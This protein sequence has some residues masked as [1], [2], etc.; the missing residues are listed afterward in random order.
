MLSPCQG[1]SFSLKMHVTDFWNSLAFLLVLYFPWEIL[2]NWFLV[3][4]G[5]EHRCWAVPV[6]FGDA[7]LK[8]GVTNRNVFFRDHR[9][10]VAGLAFFG[11]R[12]LLFLLVPGR[13]ELLLKYGKPCRE[14]QLKMFSN[15]THTRDLFGK[16]SFAPHPAGGDVRDMNRRC[17]CWLWD[18]DHLEESRED[19][20]C[21]WTME[22]L[23]Q[24][25]VWRS[26][27]GK[28]LSPVIV[29]S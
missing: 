14:E 25:C 3:H 22:L 18:A 19:A 1:S 21:Q 20:W 12:L 27:N 23:P 2:L 26:P 28:Q 6:S 8:S 4:L 9:W 10:V 17:C 11:S 5:R 24:W 29:G 16:E 7:I 15:L 13:T